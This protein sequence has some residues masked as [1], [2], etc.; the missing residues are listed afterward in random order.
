MP[1]AP[2]GARDGAPVQAVALL[3][4]AGLAEMTERAL[5]TRAYRRQ[6]SLGAALLE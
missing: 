3:R 1:D 5:H 4:G 6:M 2:R